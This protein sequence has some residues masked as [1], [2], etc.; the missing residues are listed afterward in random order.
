MER[1]HA[2]LFNLAE[3]TIT[4]AD[5]VGARRLVPVD[6]DRRAD[7]VAEELEEL[8]FDVAPVK[9]DPIVRYLDA[10]EA[11]GDRRPV[12]AVATPIRVE[13][14]IPIGLPL[15]EA[16]KAL[17][18]ERQLFVL[19][20]GGV[21][22][23]LTRSDLQQP[24][25]SMV[26]FGYVVALESAVDGLIAR[27]HG[28]DWLSLLSES[29]RNYIESIFEQRKEHNADI[30][31]LQCSNIDDRLYIVE[32]TKAIRQPLGFTSRTAFAKTAG[33]IKRLR[34]Q[35]AHG[36]TLL[37]LKSD[38]VEAIDLFFEIR[39]IAEKAWKELL[40]EAAPAG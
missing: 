31:L 9:D 25:V 6:A 37:D 35:L 2:S 18:S 32:T 17:R 16:V 27:A 39:N 19:G 13:S 34:N 5:L 24:P 28:E 38:P 11:K 8:G 12:S 10:A 14:L 23:I 3:R 21:N 1:S 30:G 36:G 22:A 26:A 29:R 7:D 20:S 33:R 4:V 15:T 40:G